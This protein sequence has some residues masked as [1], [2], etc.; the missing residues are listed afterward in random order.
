MQR[1]HVTL[2]SDIAGTCD[3]GS[4]VWANLVV[5]QGD[6]EVH[7]IKAVVGRAFVLHGKSGAYAPSCLSLTMPTC[8]CGQKVCITSVQVMQVCFVTRHHIHQFQSLLGAWSV[9]NASMPA[10]GRPAGRAAAR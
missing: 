3:A 6:S 4:R 9:L 10:P 8:V 5:R 1:Q 7:R 2:M